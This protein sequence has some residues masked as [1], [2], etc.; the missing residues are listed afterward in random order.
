MLLFEVREALAEH[1]RGG[2][3]SRTLL[4][5]CAVSVCVGMCKSG[6]GL[7]VLDA[8]PKKVCVVSQE[9]AHFSHVRIGAKGIFEMRLEK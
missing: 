9:I 4:E 8:T 6:G 1:G 3:G 2:T 7:F 5:S